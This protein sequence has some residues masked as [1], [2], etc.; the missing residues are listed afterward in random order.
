VISRDP[1][2]LP[3]LYKLKVKT[4]CTTVYQ[5]HNFYLDL[6]LKDDPN[7]VN[8]KRFNKLEQKYIDKID[9]LFTLNEPQKEL[10]SKY[11]KIPVFAGKPGLKEIK[12]I[13][14]NFANKIIFYSGSFQPKK[15]LEDLLRAFSKLKSDAKLILAGGRNNNEISLVKEL[16]EKIDINKDIE[17]TG[18]L[19]YSALLDLLKSA[20]VG[21]I[22]II[23]SFYNQY[24]T[25]PS[26]LFDYLSFGLPLVA[27][28]LPSIR[29]LV[30]ENKNCLYYEPG[31]IDQLSNRLDH[32]LNDKNKFKHC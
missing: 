9:A 6:A 18:W 2:F 29:D 16:I 23:D 17:I 26:K 4:N 13:Q 28:D 11:I 14:D 5:S 24:L 10:Y 30:P 7:E 20:T 31:N 1:A 22:P 15:G 21:V 19:E 25:A 32:I 12:G 27:S 8:A 3:Y